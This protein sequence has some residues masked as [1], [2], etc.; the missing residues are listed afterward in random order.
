LSGWLLLVAV[1][2]VL[3]LLVT[4]VGKVVAQQVDIVQVLV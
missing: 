4:L 2:V 1:V 3:V